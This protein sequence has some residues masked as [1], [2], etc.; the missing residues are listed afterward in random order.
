MIWPPTI[1]KRAAARDPGASHF[2]VV[3][4]PRRK[5]AVATRPFTVIETMCPE[6]GSVACQRATWLRVASR[7]TY[8]PCFMYTGTRNS[9]ARPTLSPAFRRALQARTTAFIRCAC[10]GGLVACCCLTVLP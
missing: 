1:V 5:T 4:F 2:D 10:D 6:H 9:R 8:E 7:K 3:R